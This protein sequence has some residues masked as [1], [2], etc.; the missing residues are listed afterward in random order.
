[1]QDWNVVIRGVGPHQTDGGSATDVE[2]LT[3][4]YIAKLT[5][6]GHVVRIA[7]ITPGDIDLTPK[8]EES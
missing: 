8:N 7:T 5:E 6:A 1:M 3:R 4:D 2:A